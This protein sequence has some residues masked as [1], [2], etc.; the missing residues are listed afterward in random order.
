MLYIDDQFVQ[1]ISPLVRNFKRKN[2][3]E[4]N[5]SC[6]C[7]GD[8]RKNKTK[9]R[10]YLYP[11]QGRVGLVYK[12]HNCGISMSFG[13][14]LK[15]CFPEVYNNYVLER[16]KSDISGPK[17][18]HN[19]I[20]DMIPKEVIKVAKQYKHATKVLD[21]SKEHFAK[22]YVLDRQIPEE[23][24]SELYFTENFCEFIKEL[25]PH[26]NKYDNLPQN[27]QRVVLLFKN[28]DGEVLGAQGRSLF[29]TKMRYIT[30]RRDD[31]T[32]LIYG[33]EN[34]TL[35]QKTYIVEGPFDSMFLP[36]CLA[37]ATSDLLGVESH[38]GKIDNCVYV[39]DNEPRN[40]E[41]VKIMCKAIRNNKTICIWPESIKQK[42]IND[43][44]LSGMSKE[45]IKEIIDNNSFSGIEAELKITSWQKI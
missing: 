28:K 7:C 25:Y 29:I 18:K 41:I 17:Q 40:R 39:F 8:S 12:C 26:V 34:H 44:V 23:Y 42:D 36:N 5:F 22:K 19:K 10:G 2:N 6:P 4:Y 21:L 11:N 20:E 37:A 30:I 1:N 9:A 16:F 43:M 35:S 14:L 13:N 27:D 15:S 32:R 31:S 24:V 38:F 3:F 33:L 45:Q